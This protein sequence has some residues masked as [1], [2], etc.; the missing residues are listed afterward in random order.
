MIDA[1]SPPP[2]A[3]CMVTTSCLSRNKPA[4]AEAD[5]GRRMGMWRAGPAELVAPALSSPR[6]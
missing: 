6:C 4:R 1:V 2:A 3:V 5:A